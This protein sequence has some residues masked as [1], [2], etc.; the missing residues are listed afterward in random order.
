MRHH[1]HLKSKEAIQ[2]KRFCASNLHDEGSCKFSKL[3]QLSS[4]FEQGT[5]EQ[6]TRIFTPW[7]THS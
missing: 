2:A 6:R 1:K 3:R 4:L 7:R 5:A